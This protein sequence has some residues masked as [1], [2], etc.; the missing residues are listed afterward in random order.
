MS[1]IKLDIKVKNNKTILNY[2]GS[3]TTLNGE[4]ID[5]KKEIVCN[6]VLNDDYLSK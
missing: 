5:Y 2:S 1:D 3:A 4:S 6:Y